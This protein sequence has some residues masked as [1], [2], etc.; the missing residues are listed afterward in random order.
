MSQ[1]KYVNSKEKNLGF[2]YVSLLF[3]CLCSL[4]VHL[5]FKHQQHWLD[6]PDKTLVIK[7]MDRILEF[8]EEQRKQSLVCDSI[9]QKIRRFQP[10]INASYEEN[11]IK[12]LISDL[13]KQYNNNTW[14]NRHKAFAQAA[15]LYEMWFIDKKKLWSVTQN[16]LTFKQNL[17]DCEIG[18]DQKLQ[19]INNLKK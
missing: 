9:Y 18:L 13:R 3:L 19:E 17:Q 4:S 10:G 7:K 11:D 6:M 12:F 1:K 14:D 2:L 5:L 8:R 15:D 16:T